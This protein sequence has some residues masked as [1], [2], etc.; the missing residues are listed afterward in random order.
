M[1]K[2]IIIQTTTD[3]QD[4]TKKLTTALLENRLS[5]DVQSSDIG[6][7]Y[8]WKG[9]IRTKNETLLTIKTK[10]SL[11]KDVEKIIRDNSLYETPQII[12][13]PII[14]GGKDYLDWI[15]E[16]TNYKSTGG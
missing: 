14:N 9:E 3:N 12:A 13:A 11:F 4:W 8:W 7:N 2:P 10:E 1:N 6:S 5:A 15:K 16:E